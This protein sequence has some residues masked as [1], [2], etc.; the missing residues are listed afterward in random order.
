MGAEVP[1]PTAFAFGKGNVFVAGYGDPEGKAPGGIFVLRGGKAVQLRG[2]P[3][4]AGLA[5]KNGTL[6]ATV[7]R[8]L[9]AFGGWNGSAFTTRRVVWSGLKRFTV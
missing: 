2:M 8:T 1:T 9:L 6:Y 7:S 4:A 3:G 5:W